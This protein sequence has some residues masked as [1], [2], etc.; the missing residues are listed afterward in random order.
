MR[1]LFSVCVIS[2]FI[3]AMHDILHH[4]HYLEKASS[5]LYFWIHCAYSSLPMVDLNIVEAKLMDWLTYIYYMFQY[6]HFDFPGV[7]PRTFIG[8]SFVL[9]QIFA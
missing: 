7:V 1:A 8:K 2:L 6:D 9:L 5:S 4:H 3:K